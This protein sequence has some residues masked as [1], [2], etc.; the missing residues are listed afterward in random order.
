MVETVFCQPECKK[1]GN[2]QFVILIKP[3]QKKC[4]RISSEYLD[5]A[6]TTNWALDSPIFKL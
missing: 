1:I 6:K 3:C 5:L 4:S 2:V